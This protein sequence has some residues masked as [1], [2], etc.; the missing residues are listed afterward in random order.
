MRVRGGYFW[1]RHCAVPH[2]GGWRQVAVETERRVLGNGQLRAALRA[3]AWA[4]NYKA[5]SWN[6]KALRKN[7]KALRKNYKA[8]G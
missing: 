3:A 1:L 8:L 7:Y 2:N 4:G 5:L 6:Y